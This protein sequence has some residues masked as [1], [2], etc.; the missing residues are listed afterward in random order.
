M[1]EGSEELLETLVAMRREIDILHT[2]STHANLL[3]DTLDSMLGVGADGDPFQ[4]VFQ[5]LLP[6]FGCSHAIVLIEKNQAQERLECIASNDEELV[7]TIWNTGHTFSKVLSGRIVTTIGGADAGEWPQHIE[8]GQSALYLPLGVRNQRGLLV[9]LREQAMPGFDRSHVRLARKFSLIASHA[10]AAIH[11]SRAEVES[12]RLK[13]LTERLKASQDELRYR[14]NHDQ[15]TGLPNRSCIQDLANNILSRKVPGEQAALA[16]IDL[17]DF[18]QVNDVYGHSAGDALLKGVAERLQAHIRKTDLIGRISGDEFVLILDPSEGPGQV[19][20][21][22]S[23]LLR[24]LQ[25]PFEIEGQQIRVSASMGVAYFPEHGGDYATLRANADTAMYQAKSSVKGSIGFFNSALGRKVAEKMVFEQRLRAAVH[26]REFRYALQPKV[27]IRDRRIVG[28][29]ALARWVD[30]RGMV[31]TPDSFL[32]LA[33]SLGLLDDIIHIV[34][35]ALVRDLPSLDACFGDNLK[36]SLN[37][38]AAQAGRMG[39][40]ETFAR[41]IADTG[42]AGNFMLELTEESFVA[43][44]PFQAHVFPLLR[45]IGVGVSIDDFGTGYSSLAILADITADELKVDRSLI[46]A[47]HQRPRSQSIL[48]AIESLSTSL[49]M[50]VVAEG[51]ETLDERNYLLTSTG[52]H[53]G[54]GFLFSRPQF[55]EDLLK[56]EGSGTAAARRSG[57]ACR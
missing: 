16:F 27:D 42:R 45:E 39:F 17:D 47:I 46:T 49:G 37:I 13:Q 10:F 4:G 28:F 34:L 2:E 57:N 33:S 35:D 32:P 19:P 29:E 5:A 36:Y 30:E 44:G 12:Q 14:A 52:I 6:V 41:R 54:Q 20:A 51:I 38:S 25:E 50:T 55:V 3:L 1:M 26:N 23:R 40:M 43:A 22:A 18:K 15:L 7:G 24:Q 56:S 11:A 21:L 48:R 9:L 31:Q 8:R 53:F